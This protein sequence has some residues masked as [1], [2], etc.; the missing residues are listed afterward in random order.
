VGTCGNLLQAIL[1]LRSNDIL[2]LAQ[3]ME[4][5]WVTDLNATPPQPNEDPY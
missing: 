4:Y 2:T 5:E 1:Q 3:V